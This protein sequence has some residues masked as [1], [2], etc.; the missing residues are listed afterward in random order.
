MGDV[1]DSEVINIDT[2][3]LSNGN[4]F[5]SCLNKETVLKQSFTIAK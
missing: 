2:K 5:I 4:Y 1:N 3:N